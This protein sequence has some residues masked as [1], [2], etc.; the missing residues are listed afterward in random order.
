MSKGTLCT[1]CPRSTS[2]LP[3]NRQLLTAVRRPRDLPLLE[4]LRQDGVMASLLADTTPA[5]VGGAWRPATQVGT[6]LVVDWAS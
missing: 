4:E 1:P 5:N 3:H 6:G 2:V